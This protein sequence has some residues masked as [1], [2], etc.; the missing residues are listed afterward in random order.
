MFQSHKDVRVENGESPSLGD[1]EDKEE[2]VKRANEDEEPP[3]KKVSKTDN[4]WYCPRCKSQNSSF[5]WQCKFCQMPKETTGHDHHHQKDARYEGFRNRHLGPQLHR[6]SGWYM[7]VDHSEGLFESRNA[8]YPNPAPAPAPL[9]QPSWE[10]EENLFSRR[11]DLDY[12]SNQRPPKPPRLDLSQN[13]SDFQE[14]FEF[15]AKVVDYG[16]GGQKDRDKEKATCSHQPKQPQGDRIAIDDLIQPPGRYARPPKMVIIFRGLPG[17]G[18]TFVAKHLKNLE[19]DMGSEAP[20][21]L[22]LDDYF[23]CDGEV[24][25]LLRLLTAK[26]VLHEKSPVRTL[27]KTYLFDSVAI[28]LN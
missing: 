28:L 7:P 2:R 15:S 8:S 25:T 20:R 1:V 9:L 6:T 26:R 23:E 5:C 4:D 18:K 3:L 24:T 10:S 14:E 21:I 13:I 16:H 11:G 22:A 17:A 27:R 19:A 12:F